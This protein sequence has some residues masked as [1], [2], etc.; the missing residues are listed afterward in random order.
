MSKIY[1]KIFLSFF[2]KANLKGILTISYNNKVYKFGKEIDNGEDIIKEAD[3]KVLDKRFF[4]K[5]I[6]KGDI[7]LGES[8]FLDYFET[9]NLKNL[10]KWFLQNKKSL[11]GFHE[12]NKKYLLFEWAK[13]ISQVIHKLNKNTK[14]GS[15]RNIHKHYDVSNDF[16]KLWLDETMTYSC[17]VFGKEDDLRSAQLRKYEKICQKVGLK[18]SDHVL[19]IGSGWGGFAIYAVQKYNCRITTTTISQKQY[20]L[21]KQ[22]IEAAGLSGKIELIL[23]DYRDLE[24]KYDKIVSIEMMEALGHEYVPL[25]VEKCDSLLKSGG[26]MCWQC[27]TLPDKIFQ[28]YLKN[29][30]YIKKYIFPGGELISLGQL[31]DVISNHK[32]LHINEIERIGLDYAKTLYAWAKNLKAHKKEVM[33]LGFDE[34]FF[35]KWL[36]YF[37]YCEVGFATGYL[38]D[39][40]ILISKD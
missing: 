25:F 15:K 19:E 37:E 1:K 39:A 12:N 6:W 9:N 18:S 29:N 22:R 36:Y 10:L 20:N 14:F 5:I 30:N 8:Y 16:Y 4:Q 23:K 35:K 21:A 2:S 38:D 28:A 24:G 3:I 40:Q 11:P 32:K 26:K 33:K 13:V 34:I 27:I 31:Q 7:G 17:A